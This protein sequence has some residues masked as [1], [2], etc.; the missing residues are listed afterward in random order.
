MG[1]NMATIIY[2][3]GGTIDPDEPKKLPCSNPI[4][5]EPINSMIANAPVG[6]AYRWNEAWLSWSYDAFTHRTQPDP[7]AI[8]GVAGYTRDMHRAWVATM[9]PQLGMGTYPLSHAPPPFDPNV[10]QVYQSA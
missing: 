6:S 5:C 9:N 4:D 1:N 3:P 8:I 2:P 10:V 7:G